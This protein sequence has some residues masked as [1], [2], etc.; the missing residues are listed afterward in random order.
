MTLSTI[1]VKFRPVI[2]TVSRS[3]AP[4]SNRLFTGLT[5]GSINNYITFFMNFLV[6]SKVK[7]ICFGYTT[8]ASCFLSWYR[9]RW[10][11]LKSGNRTFL[12]KKYLAQILKI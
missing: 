6:D 11:K 9:A 3:K 12:L 2:E 5:V 1:V 10:G 8:N 4:W 7:H